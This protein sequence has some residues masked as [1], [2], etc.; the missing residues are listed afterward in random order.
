MSLVKPN[1]VTVLSGV[2]DPRRPQHNTKK[3][4]LID[5]IVIAVVGCICGA[6]SWV[7]IADFG[8]ARQSWFEQFLELAN[9]I[10]SPDTFGRV[11]SILDPTAFE[12]CF[13]NWT[14]SLVTLRKGTVVA[15]DGK[16]SR[17]SRQKQGKPLHLVNA[18]ATD[19][20]I[21]LG[22]RK[23]DG[24]SNEITAIPEL[25][26][27]LVLKGCIITADAMATQGA[28]VKKVIEN[29]GDY[30][31][32]VKG[33]QRRMLADCKALFTAVGT[34]TNTK[35]TYALQES[36]EHGRVETRECFVSTDLSGIRDKE[37]WDGL[38]SII[39]LVSTR[40]IAG[41]T[42]TETRY[43]ISSLELAAGKFMSV[44]RSHWRIENSLHWVLDVVF[45]EDQSRVR[46]GYAAEN[47]AYVRKLALNI[48]A[49]DTTRT[50]SM[51]RKTRQAA[52]NTGYLETLLGLA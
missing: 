42:S 13:F 36:R 25:L 52:W 11:F 48:L 38:S 30:V 40:T 45:K 31:F 29:K 23:V 37:R 32:A 18:F 5:I 9:G 27:L 16:A 39:T 22:Q 46:M 10:P 19:T 49:S 28:I 41:Q 15:L 34:S 51:R 50:V 44:I 35:R 33:N 3:H 47:L 17:A 14:Q 20:G 6:E 12:Q 26:D 24:K 8:V 2:P 4:A 21:A 7:D 1:I 43:Y